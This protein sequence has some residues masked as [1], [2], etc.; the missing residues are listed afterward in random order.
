[1]SG[2]EKFFLYGTPYIIILLYAVGYFIRKR[3]TRD[4]LGHDTVV[5]FNNFIKEV[6]EQ[7]KGYKADHD[8]ILEMNINLRKICEDLQSGK[9]HMA[10]NDFV[11]DTHEV[12]LSNHARAFDRITIFHVQNH[13]PDSDPKI[14]EL[15]ERPDM[16]SHPFL[17]STKNNP[18]G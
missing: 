17:R 11:L 12:W 5:K 8:I 14:K 16:S 4:E 10:F 9:T 3:I 1:M 7:M 18:A 2:L 6:R 13:G 15:A